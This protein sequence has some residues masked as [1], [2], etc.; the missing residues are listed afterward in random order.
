MMEIL[1]IMLQEVKDRLQANAPGVILEVTNALMDLVCQQGYDRSYGARPLRRAVTQFIEVVL[2]EALLS[3]NY[4]PGDTILIDANSSGSAF[5][6]P[7]PNQKT[8]QLA[9]PASAN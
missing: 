1:N 9:D 3:G 2:S 4:K 5:V 7:Q 6:S 8:V